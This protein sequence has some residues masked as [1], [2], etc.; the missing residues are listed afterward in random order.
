MTPES[1]I[2]ECANWKAKVDYTN[3]LN[4][5]NPE[6]NV[7]EVATLAFEYIFANTYDS[8]KVFVFE[9]KDA[10]GNDYFNNMNMKDTPDPLFAML[11]KVYK[12][13]DEHDEDK[14]YFVLTRIILENASLP[15]ML[16]DLKEF[17]KMIKKQN[18]SFYN[19]II[20]IFKNNSVI[21]NLK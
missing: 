20:K 8:D 13:T 12:N 19:N 14:H 2:V 16:V 11:T 10:A 18:K 7:V 3:S 9:L 4:Y 15:H 1:Y 17:E 5:N 21:T 6:Q